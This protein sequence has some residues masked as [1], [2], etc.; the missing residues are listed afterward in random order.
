[1]KQRIIT[2]FLL[3][4]C[5][6][7]GV[8]AFFVSVTKDKKAPVISVSEKEITYVEGA[9]YSSLLEGVTAEDNRDG[10]VTDK[11]FVDRVI[12]MA[13]EE[14]AIVY[15]AAADKSNNVGTAKRVVKYSKDGTV[16]EPEKKEEDKKDDPEASGQEGQEA[17]NQEPADEPGQGLYPPDPVD[18]SAG[19]PVVQVKAQ[20]ST[21]AVGSVVNLMD[22]INQI[23]DAD[24]SNE[25]HDYMFAHV[26]ITVDGAQSTSTFSANAAGSHEIQYMAG[27]RNGAVSEPTVM[28]LI[29]Q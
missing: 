21:V 10:D 28:T 23:H 7:L 17:D 24:M 15:Y 6:I 13:G 14:E 25:N 2:I 4:S 27:N 8:A 19:K 5:V 22:F 11:V 20:Q 26:S 9:G 16:A 18:T 1:M 12:P 3:V 29:V